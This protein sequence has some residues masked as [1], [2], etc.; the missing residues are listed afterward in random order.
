MP[1]AKSQ[2]QNAKSQVIMQM[3]MFISKSMQI[4]DFGMKNF[5]ALGNQTFSGNLPGMGE[6]FRFP[7][8]KCQSVAGTFCMFPPIDVGTLD[9]TL[10]LNVH[11]KTK[12]G[13]ALIRFKRS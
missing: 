4:R 7:G 1:K 9:M 5:Q 10:V 6:L 12:T 8:G 11:Q 3:D 13:T 2:K